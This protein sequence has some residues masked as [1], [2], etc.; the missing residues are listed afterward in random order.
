MSEVVEQS[1]EPNNL[2]PRRQGFA[3]REEIDRRMPIPFVGD[4][5]ENSTRQLHDPEGVLESTMSRAWVNEIRQRELVDVAKTLKRTRVDRRH[6]VRGDPH[7]VM[8][9]VTDLMLMLGHR[10]N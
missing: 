4:D 9:R 10:R 7:E 5:V 6:F 8:D 2:A 3:V 1:C